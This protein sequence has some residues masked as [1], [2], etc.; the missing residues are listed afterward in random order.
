MPQVVSLKNRDGAMATP[1]YLVLA[2]IWAIAFGVVEGSPSK[3]DICKGL[4]WNEVL[5]RGER[6]SE[7]D[8][9]CLVTF[10][11]SADPHKWETKLARVLLEE[12]DAGL[13]PESAMPRL[14]DEEGLPKGGLKRGWVYFYVSVDSNGIPISGCVDGDFDLE[15][16]LK[17]LGT[18]LNSRYR[19]A[20]AGQQFIRSIFTLVFM[21]CD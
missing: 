5:Q 19:P 21:R 13:S 4:T 10:L 3:K 18:L 6:R 15:E 17:V 12:W 16:D 8:R 2:L 9:E 20:R 14:L 11:R 7:N 1:V